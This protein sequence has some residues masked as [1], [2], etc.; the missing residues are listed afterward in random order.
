MAK[1][2]SQDTKSSKFCID[3]ESEFIDEPSKKGKIIQ[4]H[5]E[6]VNMDAWYYIYQ[7]YVNPT[8]DIKK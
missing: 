8:R 5:L 6:N 4:E 2:E 3:K 7:V 1:N